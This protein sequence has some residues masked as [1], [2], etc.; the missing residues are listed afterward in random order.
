M[1]LSFFPTHTP[2][3]V[4]VLGGSLVPLSAVPTVASEKN[5]FCATLGCVEFNFRCQ[6]IESHFHQLDW[7]F[8][9]TFG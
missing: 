6:L 4:F 9:G 5:H 8:F 7:T 2:A 3:N 1:V